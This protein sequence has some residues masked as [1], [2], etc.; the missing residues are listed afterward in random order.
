M[1]GKNYGLSTN[2][3]DA[4]I[5]IQTSYAC[6]SI[7][8]VQRQLRNNNELLHEKEGGP[9]LS[10]YLEVRQATSHMNV[11]PN[12]NFQRGSLSK[13]KNFV[14]VPIGIEMVTSQP[15]KELS[16]KEKLHQTLRRFRGAQKHVENDI[17]QRKGTTNFP[18]NLHK[19][20]KSC[21]PLRS[22]VVELGQSSKK[23]KKRD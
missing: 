13:G 22:N 21:D 9:S 8:K 17:I 3:S 19:E 1:K 2:G 15:E 12:K 23:K 5:L 10:K 18:L 11:A 6:P 7:E 20:K 14:Q 16:F 4:N